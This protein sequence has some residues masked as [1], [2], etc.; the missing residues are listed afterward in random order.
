MFCAFISVQKEW[1]EANSNVLRSVRI[2][3][4]IVSVLSIMPRLGMYIVGTLTYS[5]L[6]GAP[7]LSHTLRRDN[8]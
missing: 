5:V 1:M 4:S 6:I 7:I 3:A 2:L 8:I